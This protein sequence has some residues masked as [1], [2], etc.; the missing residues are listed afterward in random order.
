[1]RKSASHTGRRLLMVE[2][3][4]RLREMLIRAMREMGFDP[5]GAGSAEEALRLLAEC[6]FPVLLVD[7][8][9]RGNSGMDLLRSVRT[10]YPRTQAIILT[11]FGDLEAAKQAIHLDVVDFLTKPC[12]LGDLELALGRAFQRLRT[13]DP[14]SLLREP[15][16]VGDARA[17]DSSDPSLM[18]QEALS[19]EFTPRDGSRQHS[20]E[21]IERQTILEVLERN[22]G[23]RNVTATELGISVRK[24]YYRLAQ[25]QKRGF[26]QF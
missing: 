11:G 8:N 6:P 25:Y 4:P 23:N 13:I 10:L 18:Q 21:D 15:L 24:L 9:L 3:E 2:D 20:M 12:A 26:L 5:S 1:M 7:L 16:E 17:F 22:K 14:A 19:L